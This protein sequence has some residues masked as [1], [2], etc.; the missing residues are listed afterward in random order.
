[1]DKEQQRVAKGQLVALMQAGHSWQEAVTFTELPISRPSAYR[2]VQRVR[3]EGL[4][5]LQ[6]GRHGH[7]TKLRE[8]V[9]HWLKDFC[10]AAPQTPS[11]VVQQELQKHFGLLVSVS[12]LNATRAALGMG[13]RP[14]FCR[15][16]N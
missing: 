15:E 4:A 8:P 1:M 12:H 13:S 9:L 2:L 10:Q 16:K 11:H 14:R 3:T 7:P 5:A 6:D